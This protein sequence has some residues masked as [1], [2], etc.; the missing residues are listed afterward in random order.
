LNAIKSLCDIAI[1]SSARAQDIFGLA[2]A[3]G[4]F[5]A[6]RRHH[7]ARRRA[8]KPAIKKSWANAIANWFFKRHEQDLLP[9]RLADI[10]AGL[11]KSGLVTKI[12]AT[13]FKCVGPGFMRRLGGIHRRTEAQRR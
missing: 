1:S 2:F 10:P 13:V 12:V 6:P 9:W 3:I 4:I 11:P 8:I 5:S 7:D